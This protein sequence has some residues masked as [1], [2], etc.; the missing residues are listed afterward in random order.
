VSAPA[1]DPLT[2]V[3]SFSGWCIVRLPTDPDPTDEPRGVSGYTF[4]FAGEP[5]LD[6]IIYL[7]PPPNFTPRSHTPPLGVTV[8]SA[9]RTDGVDVPAMV[10]ATV[11]LLNGPMLQNRN[12]TLTLPGYEPIVPFDLRI[13]GGATLERSAPLNPHDVQQP[14]WQV[15]QPL[16]MAQG[17]HGMEYEPATIGE[18]TGVW[19]SLRVVEQRLTDLQAELEHTTD[20]TART[21]LE[22]RIAELT[23]A[24]ANP[25]DRRVLARY[26]VERFGFPMVGS[27][28]V[29]DAN[30][31]LGGTIDRNDPW[32]INFW[33]G[34]W[35]PDLLCMFMKG[36]LEVPYA[37]G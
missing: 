30:K 3:L 5:D 33:F 29:A 7:Q 37:A 18:A 20:Q 32:M 14:V 8:T 26:F 2:L 27:A 12:W 25:R 6:R 16:L 1:P 13:D 10:G 23:F 21:A 34:A 36:A 4:A 31:V 22:G 17:A 35:D 24:A 15:P 28:F 19:D 9:V 11:D